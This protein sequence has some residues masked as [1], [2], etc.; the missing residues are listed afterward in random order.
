MSPR[1]PESASHTQAPQARTLCWEVIFSM[2]TFLPAPGMLHA[3]TA[4]P[5]LY[6]L[7]NTKSPDPSSKM[8]VHGR[9]S[10]RFA[11]AP[12]GEPHRTIIDTQPLEPLRRGGCP[13]LVC[14]GEEGQFGG[15][16]SRRRGGA[17]RFRCWALDRTVT[18]SWLNCEIR[19]PGCQG[20]SRSRR[21]NS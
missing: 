19:M 7:L 2:K 21:S 9:K 11:S 18:I 4:N 5:S 15:W 1:D 12:A 16:L 3:P 20:T 17:Y 10:S 14:E 8:H 13:E 6:H